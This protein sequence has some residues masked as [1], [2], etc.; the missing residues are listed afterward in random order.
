MFT[1]NLQAHETFSRQEKHMS[2]ELTCSRAPAAAPSGPDHQPRRQ[3]APTGGR[4]RCCR[5]TG[6]TKLR[7]R[8]LESPVFGTQSHIENMRNIDAGKNEREELA[9]NATKD[10]DGFFRTTIYAANRQK[11]NVHAHGDGAITAPAKTIHC[12][13]PKHRS[14]LRS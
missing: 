6:W 13:R 2:G 7:P 9:S 14:S 11:L 12:P 10:F 3:A 8:Q 4:Y 1:E 5:R